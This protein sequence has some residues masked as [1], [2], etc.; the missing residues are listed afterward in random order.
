MSYIANLE[1]FDDAFVVQNVLDDTKTLVIGLGGAT[2]STRMTL[3]S[4]QTANRTITFPDISGTL[5]TANSVDTLTNKTIT[6]ASNNVGA[7]E[8]KTTGASVVIAGASP[9]IVGQVL[10][11]I[12]PIVAEWIS[13][14]TL[15]FQGYL[16]VQQ[17]V[18]TAPTDIPINTEVVKDSPFTHSVNSAEIAITTDGNYLIIVSASIMAITGSS[19]SSAEMWLNISTGSGFNE[20]AGTRRIIYVRRDPYGGSVAFERYIS[21]TAG[22]VIKVQAERTVGTANTVVLSGQYIMTILSA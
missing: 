21:M 18:T 6:D 19:R 15:Y 16:S 5:I 7:N 17:T 11:A 14:Q 1:T 20:V 8:L 22:D 9:P 3:N 4:I 13:V 12:S 2:A 10:Q